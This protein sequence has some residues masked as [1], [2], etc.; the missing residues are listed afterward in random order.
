MRNETTMLAESR[1]MVPMRTFFATC[2]PRRAYS[3]PGIM[4]RSPAIE[5]PTVANAIPAM[6]ASSP[7]VFNRSISGCRSGG[8]VQSS[9]GCAAAGFENRVVAIPR[10]SACLSGAPLVLALRACTGSDCTI[11]T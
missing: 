2:F 4:N 3:W 8:T 9:A 7:I 11:Q 5:N 10:R 1:M 6:N